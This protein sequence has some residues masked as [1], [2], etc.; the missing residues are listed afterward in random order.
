MSG[1]KFA[2]ENGEHN[3]PEMMPLYS[4]HY[5]EMRERL[6]VDGIDIP[7]FK[8]RLQ[9]YFDGMNAGHILNYIVRTDA[10]EAVGYANIYLTQD[11]HNSEYIAQE[12]TVFIIKAH[13]NG[14]GK[15]LVQF[16]LDDL[17]KRGVKRVNITPVTDLR[18]GKIWERM[19]FKPVA[20]VMTY[21]F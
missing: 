2:L 4:Q 13:R 11:M 19:G 7:E 10:G 5:T 9:V 8:P 15:K 1:Y 16:I 12:D 20:Q 14:I 6:S 18:V 21:I 3:C 17:R